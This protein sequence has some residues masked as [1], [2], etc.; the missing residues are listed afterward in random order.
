MRYCICEKDGTACR[1]FSEGYNDPNRASA[2]DVPP[3]MNPWTTHTGRL[4]R[5]GGVHKA[6]TKRCTQKRYKDTEE[7]E[8]ES[9]ESTQF[10]PPSPLPEATQHRHR[11]RE[12]T[13]EELRQAGEEQER[14]RHM[15]RE[16]WG[17]QMQELAEEREAAERAERKKRSAAAKKGWARRKQKEQEGSDVPDWLKWD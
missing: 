7:E 15:T 8:E 12:F 9:E 14:M 1:Q 2:N 5:D 10:A 11:G 13:E 17:P 6:V 16:T 3:D 4:A